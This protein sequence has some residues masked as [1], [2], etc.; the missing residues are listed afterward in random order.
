M[1]HL[2]DPEY[3]PDFYDGV[4][5]KRLIAWIVDS[6]IIFV[7][8]ALVVVGTLFIGAFFWPVLWLVVDFSY[9]VITLT[10]GSAT[11]GMRFAGI[12]LRDQTG[13]RFDLFQ[14][15]AHTLGYMVSMALPILQI[16]SIVMMLTGA[17]KQGLTD[18][19]LGSV[20]LNRRAM[21]RA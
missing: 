1:I 13:A 9:R 4:P 3:R 21:L 20:A 6:V 2:P 14:A 7:L 17:R 12:E 15:G 10:T 8:S 11:L 16:V 18:M 5:S 19:V